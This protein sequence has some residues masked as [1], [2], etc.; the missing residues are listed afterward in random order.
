MISQFFI[1][2]FCR[3][4]IKNYL[5]A[6]KYKQPLTFMKILVMLPNEI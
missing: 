6:A 2:I 1:E 4:E 5:C 3:F